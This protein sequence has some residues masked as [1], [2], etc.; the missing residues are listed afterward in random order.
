MRLIVLCNNWTGWQ[1]LRWLVDQREQVVGV[2]VHPA[3]SAKHR[4]EIVGEARRVECAS[5]FDGDQLDR[6]ETL[7][8]IRR[9]AP[10]LGISVNFGY[11]LRPRF[12][13]LFPRGVVNLHAGY[14]P[15]NR[16][17]YPN[18][19]SIVEGTPA[20]VTL[21]YVDTGI[22]TGDIIAQREV[23]VDPTDTGG[24]LYRKLERAAVELFRETWPLLKRGTAPRI[25][26]PRDQGTFHRVRD[27]ERID[28]LELDRLYPARELLNILRARTFPPY[29]GAYFEE[30]GRRIYVTIHLEE[31]RDEET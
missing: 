17:A 10:E 24:S 4:D 23:P 9:L 16:G 12:L 22:D 27:V 2:V 5:V 14:L 21:H 30:N 18:V 29:K 3:R 1:V 11:I 26:Q 15:Y 31:A 28:R 8:S 6:E 7:E 19:W 20:G 25:P 13:A